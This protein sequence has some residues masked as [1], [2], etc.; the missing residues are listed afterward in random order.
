MRTELTFASLRS[1]PSIALA[2][3]LALTEAAISIAPG[4]CH[5]QI[6]DL[7]RTGRAS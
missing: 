6:R 5:V 4:Q 1:S 7:A 3:V 2:L